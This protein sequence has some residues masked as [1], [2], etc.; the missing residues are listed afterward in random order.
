MKSGAFIVALGMTA[1]VS[2]GTASA[3]PSPKVTAART[4]RAEA[5]AVA[6]AKMMKLLDEARSAGRARGPAADWL[7]RQFKREPNVSLLLILN[8]ILG[9]GLKDATSWIEPPAEREPCNAEAKAAVA[10]H[11]GNTVWL[12]N[13]FYKT[14]DDENALTLFHEALHLVGYEDCPSPIT[15]A[16]PIEKRI[17]AGYL[18]EMLK[19]LWKSAP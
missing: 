10:E 1:L 18:E 4:R 14:N 3:D 16:T 2:G 11:G 19:Y 5:V 12:C 13:S 8:S 7:Q 15:S 17:C 6:R 9:Y